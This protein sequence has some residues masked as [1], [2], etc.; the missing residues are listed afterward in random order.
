MALIADSASSGGDPGA[1]MVPGQSTAL[2][3]AHAGVQVVPVVRDAGTV[4]DRG[5]VGLERLDHW[6]HWHRLSEGRLN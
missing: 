5:E 6:W 2:V 4:D 3:A 1:R